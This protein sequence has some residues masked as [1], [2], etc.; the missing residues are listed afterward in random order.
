M[1]AAISLC[2]LALAEISLPPPLPAQS[3]LPVFAHRTGGLRAAGLTESSGVAV[4]RRYP[5]VLWTHNDSGDESLIYAVDSTGRRLARFRVRNARV[6]DWEDIALGPCPAVIGRDRHCLYIGDTGDNA[7]RRPF[8]TLYVVPEPDPTAAGDT[9]AA[10]QPAHAL[11]IR[12]AD[13]AHD[14]EAL[15]AD[16]GGAVGIITKGR[17]G[18]ILRY[19]IPESDLNQDS[20]TI[21]PVDT[22][23]IAPQ[24]LLGRWV[25]GAA[26]APSGRLA[27]VRTYTDLYFFTIERGRWTA[28]ARPCRLGLIEPQ[29]EGVDFLDEG[30]RRLVLTSE[31]GLA[32]EGVVTIV[33][34]PQ[35]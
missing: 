18:P 8:V 15:V 6:R 24:L 2:A 9:V 1:R 4:S 21:Q 10:T 25:T 19:W 22:L 26:I 34:C 11:Q 7:E 27:V 31:R 23:P 13:G 33:R 28:Q 16:P 35:K 30:S 32:A 12:Y 3:D 5:G 17:S 29:G 20:V 14:A